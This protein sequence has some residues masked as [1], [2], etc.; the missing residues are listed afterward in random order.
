LVALNIDDAPMTLTLSEFGHRDGRIVSGSG[1][2][3]E[4]V[5]SAAEIE[6]HGWLVIAPT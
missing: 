5:V 4:D 2:P 1:A 6:P 3:P